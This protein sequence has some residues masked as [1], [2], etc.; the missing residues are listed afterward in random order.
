MRD[1]LEILPDAMIRGVRAEEPLTGRLIRWEKGISRRGPHQVAVLEE[2]E[3][4]R[5]L[6]IW[7]RPGEDLQELLPR[8][9]E[10]VLVSCQ[11]GTGPGRRRWVLSPGEGPA[12]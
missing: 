11:Q 8:A 4:G 9:G 7:L 6:R 12:K 2:L 10:M 3:T 5:V 1:L